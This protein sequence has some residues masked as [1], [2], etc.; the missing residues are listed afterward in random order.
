MPINLYFKIIKLIIDRLPFGV[1]KLIVRPL[2]EYVK[3]LKR[4]IFIIGYSP[5]AIILR[6]CS[7][8]VPNFKLDRIGHLMLEPDAYLKEHFLQ[9]A[10]FPRALILANHNTCANN[11]M[12][13]YWSKYFYTVKNPVL[14]RLLSPLQWH[15]WTC[16]DLQS[17]AVAINQSAEAYR[18][19]REWQG[20]R[21]LLK[22]TDN[23]QIMGKRSLEHLGIPEGAWYVCVHAREGGYS[24]SDEAV[25]S[26]RNSN[27]I[28]DFYSAMDWVISKGGYCIRMGDSSMVPLLKKNGYID[29][30]HSAIKSERLDLYLAG[31]CSFFIG[32]NSGAYSMATVF[33][34]PSVVV[35]LAPLSVMPIGNDDIGIPMLYERDGVLLSFKEILNSP[36][37]NFRSS[38]QYKDANISL[39]PNSAEEI[40]HLVMEQYSR[41]NNTY[42]TNSEDENWQSAF[43]SLFQNNSYAFGASAKIGTHFLKKYQNLFH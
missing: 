26:F 37:G 3:K 9:A 2:Y 22:L 14:A 17:F 35:G 5:P 40:L 39:I 15:P 1:S 33:G 28:S 10:R 13:N 25:H 19:Q 4:I 41:V 23:H 43:K 34:R 31:T 8:Q 12:I 7:V 29:Y 16:H 6:C 20:R 24:P 18:I 11:E 30:A 42:I 36:C 27:R 21:P 32:S 38:Q